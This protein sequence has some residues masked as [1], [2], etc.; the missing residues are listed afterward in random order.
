MTR[1]AHLIILQSDETDEPLEPKE[2]RSGVLRVF[3]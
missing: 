1:R 3:I 2:G